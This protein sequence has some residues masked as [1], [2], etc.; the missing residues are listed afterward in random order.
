MKKP[1]KQ[2]TAGLQRDE[3]QRLIILA[4]AGDRGAFSELVH[5]NLEKIYSLAFS[6]SRNKYDAEEI[7]Q[8][9]FLKAIKNIQSFR[10]ESSFGTWLYRITVN[11]YLNTIKNRVFLPLDE[12]EKSR[13]AERVKIYTS[14]KSK[15]ELNNL[16]EKALVNLSEKERAVFVLRHYEEIKINEIAVMLGISYG[17]VRTLLYRAVCKLRSEFS[18][19]DSPRMNNRRN[20]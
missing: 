12:T 16:I 14:G 9:V 17:T 15:N 7:A 19:P 10:G 8:E 1:I 2:G 3:E 4:Q 11:T 5:Y 6:L 20:K 13:E 18:K